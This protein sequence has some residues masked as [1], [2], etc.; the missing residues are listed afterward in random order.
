M[1]VEKFVVKACCGKTSTY[2]KIN[3]PIN[4]T[5]LDSLVSSGFTESEHFTK[6]G[7]LYINSPY[8]VV[9]GSFGSNRLQVKCRTTN[10]SEKVDEFESLLSKLE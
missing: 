10:C 7:L 4:K 6:A 8:L 1:K 3:A 2:F 9:T 5:I